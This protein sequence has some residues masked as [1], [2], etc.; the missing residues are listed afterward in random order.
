[1]VFFGRMDFSETLI[2]YDTETD[3]INSEVDRMF[4]L[5]SQHDLPNKNPSCENC[6]YALRRAEIE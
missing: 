6:A 4:D 2:P 3:W 1:M 5:L